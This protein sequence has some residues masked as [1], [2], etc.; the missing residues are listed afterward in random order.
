MKLTVNE[1]IN[2]RKAFQSRKYWHYELHHCILRSQRKS[3]IFFWEHV[4]GLSITEF[5]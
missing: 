5:I 3:I 1:K 4:N 2:I